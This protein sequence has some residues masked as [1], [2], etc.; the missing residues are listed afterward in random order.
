MQQMFVPVYARDLGYV[1]LLL[2]WEEMQRLTLP[3]TLSHF[4]F[5]FFLLH[6]NI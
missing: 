1:S 6:V 3:G 4:A 2:S 5:T